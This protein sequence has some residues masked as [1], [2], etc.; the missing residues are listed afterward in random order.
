MIPVGFLTGLG[1]SHLTLEE[2]ASWAAEH[3]CDTL[4]ISCGPAGK[5]S[6]HLDLDAVLHDGPGAVKELMAQHGLAISALT[7]NLNMLAPDASL[8]QEYSDYVRKAIDACALLGVPDVVTYAGSA[9]GMYFFGNPGTERSANYKVDENLAL[10]RD[11][12]EP[13]SKYAEEK[14]VRIALDTAPRGGGHGNIAHSPYLW[15]R[16]FDLVPSP[17][18]GL[19]FDPSHLVWIMTGPVP[20]T[21]RR[22]KDRIFRFDGKDCAILRDV[23]HEQGILSNAWWRYRLPGRGELDWKAMLDTLNEIGYT[24]VIDIENEDDQVPGL[25]GVAQGIRYIKELQG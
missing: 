4:A 5:R 25:L 15:D 17:A 19:A 7:P 11:I 2:V 1:G 24:G 13:L 21:I 9:Y 12:F 10:F 23:L 6:G 14:G 20:D 16:V 8:R 3:D 22:Y 18:L